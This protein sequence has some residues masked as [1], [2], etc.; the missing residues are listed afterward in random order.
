VPATPTPTRDTAGQAAIVAAA[1][2]AAVFAVALL[3]TLVARLPWWLPVLTALIAGLLGFAVSGLLLV[4]DNRRLV[5]HAEGLMR[6]DLDRDGVVGRPLM[7]TERKVVTL[8]LK[9]GKR[10][11][12]IDLPLTEDEIAQ[13]ARAVKRSGVFSRRAM[14]EGLM[15]TET[16]QDVKD[17]LLAAGLLRERGAG[18]SAGVELTK[19]GEWWIG[20]YME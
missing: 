15:T 11:R 2:A 8:E 1:T 9:E 12:Y 17:R 5:W 4:W 16:Y 10:L 20:R 7:Q 19:S 13:M 3:V 18:P 6:V 14:P